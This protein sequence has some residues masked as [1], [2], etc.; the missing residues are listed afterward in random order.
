MVIFVVV[1]LEE[2]ENEDG[3][4][5][6]YGNNHIEASQ[7]IKESEKSVSW[8]IAA[9]ESLIEAKELAEDDLICNDKTI[10]DT[11]NIPILERC[12]EKLK[13]DAEVTTEILH[14][15][16]RC[17]V[18]VWRCFSGVMEGMVKHLENLADL[19]G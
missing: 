15:K 7:N 6:E 9:F 16:G 8:Y 10:I 11:P 5:E 19:F 1:G 3:I 4:A 2:F 13:Y 17:T 12:K 18:E 14:G